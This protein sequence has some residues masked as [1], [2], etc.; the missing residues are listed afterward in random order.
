M[1]F[2]WPAFASLIVVAGPWKAAIVYAEKTVT[3]SRQARRRTAI[4]TVVIAT[5]VAILLLLFGAALVDL[6]HV[7][8]PAFLIASGAIVFVFAIQMVLND[9]DH[10]ESRFTAQEDAKAL[11]VAAYPLAVPVLITPPAVAALVAIGIDA[12]AREVAL[13]GAVLALGA[14]MLFNLGVFFIL[15]QYEEWVPTLAWNVAGRVLGIFL[16]AF[17]VAVIIDGLK[18]LGVVS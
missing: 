4:G 8:E 3:M 2:F 7:N 10:D 18:I 16:A 5:A 11:E 6:F 12:A 13:M 15:S 17:G 9:E 1:D 14:V